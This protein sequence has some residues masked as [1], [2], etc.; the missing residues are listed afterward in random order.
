MICRSGG[1]NR[2]YSGGGVEQRRMALLAGSDQVFGS[3]SGAGGV[4][5]TVSQSGWRAVTH[6]LQDGGHNTAP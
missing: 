6:E 1:R 3:V 4:K 2:L 5:G